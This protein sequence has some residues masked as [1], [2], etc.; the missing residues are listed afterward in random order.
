[1]TRIIGEYPRRFVKAVV[2]LAVLGLFALGLSACSAK[3][4]P[5]QCALIVGSGAGDAHNIKKVFLPG[6]KVEKGDDQSYFLPCGERNYQI[7]S[8][9]GDDPDTT[10]LTGTTAGDSDIPGIPVKVQLSMYFTLNEDKDSLKEFWVDLCRKYKCA[11]TSADEG[12]QS[13]TRQSVPGWL[14]LLQQNFTPALQRATRQAVSDFGPDL[15]QQ[16]GQSAW[17]K[18]GDEISKD[19]MAQIKSMTNA[20]HPFFCATS[21]GTNGAC[22]PVTVNINKVD[23][24]D[25]SVIKIYNEGIQ[26]DQQKGLNEKKVAQAKELYGDNWAYVLGMEDLINA[27]NGNPK[28]TCIVSLGGT[29]APAVTVP[30]PS[31][32]KAR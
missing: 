28:A 4:Y 18:L 19:F 23:P 32:T 25:P 11:S 22:K 14:D 10:Y 30:N 16:Q 7:Q 15:W 1:M 13:S 29:N 9:N 8:H 27:C 24:A 2:A 3:A 12:D 31:P 26:Q 17:P 21:S 6:E 20:S 5:D